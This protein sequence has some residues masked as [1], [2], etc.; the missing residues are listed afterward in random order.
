MNDA[1]TRWARL[2]LRA[3]AAGITSYL[4]A[5]AANAHGPLLWLPVT[6][7]VVLTVEAGL[8]KSPGA[9]QGDPVKTQIVNE[10]DKP[11]P[12]ERVDQP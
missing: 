5:T 7:A 12:V 2:F 8:S 9:D 1:G 6:S 10:P 3:V 4:T 11:V